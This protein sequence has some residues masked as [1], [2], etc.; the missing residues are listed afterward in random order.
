MLF[1]GNATTTE[2]AGVPS[3]HGVFFQ[4]DQIGGTLRVDAYGFG[5]NFVANIL[6]ITA[7]WNRIIVLFVLPVDFRDRVYWSMMDV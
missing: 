5:A 4:Y 1:S 6:S 7:W 3:E 2:G